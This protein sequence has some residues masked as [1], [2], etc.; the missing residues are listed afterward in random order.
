MRFFYSPK[1]NVITTTLTPKRQVNA[2]RTF[3]LPENAPVP[4]KQ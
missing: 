1:M 4:K 2:A 3:K